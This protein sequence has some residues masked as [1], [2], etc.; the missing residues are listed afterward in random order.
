MANGAAGRKALGRSREDGAPCGT[1]LQDH[2]HCGCPDA[3][4]LLARSGN[5]I[6][7]RRQPDLLADPRHNPQMI[8]SLDAHPR[9][10][11]PPSQCGAP[12]SRNGKKWTPPAAECGIESHALCFMNS[13]YPCDL[14]ASSKLSSTWSRAE[15]LGVGLGSIM[16]PGGSVDVARVATRQGVNARTRTTAGRGG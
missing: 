9:N 5:G 2:G 8:Q 6:Q 16:H 7:I 4:V 1:D 12:A 11:A 10:D 14:V 13:M 3:H 15:S